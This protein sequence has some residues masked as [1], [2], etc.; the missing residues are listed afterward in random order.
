MGTGQNQNFWQTFPWGLISVIIAAVALGVTIVIFFKTRKRKTLDYSL[1]DD[2]KI[3]SDRLSGIRGDIV[4]TVGG[5]AIKDPRIVTVRYMNTGNQEI[6]KS[7][8]LANSITT[9]DA[10][11]TVNSQL[12]G[13]SE[14][15]AV[16]E[17]GVVPHKSY[18][19]DCLNPGD[20][21]EIQ[22]ILDMDGIDSDA[23]FAPVCRIKGATRPAKLI[24][25]RFTREELLKA[26]RRALKASTGPTI[27]F[28]G[29]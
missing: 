14:H 24:E 13:H 6:L 18:R 19:A 7:D 3:L 27:P 29:F 10:S 5:S 11:G 20:Y 8:F 15:I 26:L 17:S 16:T 23:P 1:V 22:Y 12:A 9:T 28:P 4:V 21:L 2:V 25:P